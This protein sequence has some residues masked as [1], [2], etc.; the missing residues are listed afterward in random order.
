M[1]CLL[2]F[3][4]GFALL[5]SIGFLPGSGWGSPPA[6]TPAQTLKSDEKTQNAMREY[7]GSLNKNSKSN[8]KAKHK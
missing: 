4:V 3:I 8:T 1:R 7:Y 2:P 6:K 5:L